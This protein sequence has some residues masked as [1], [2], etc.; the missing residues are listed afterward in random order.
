MVVDGLTVKVS[1][2]HYVMNFVLICTNIDT[3]EHA[4]TYYAPS[5]AGKAEDY[6]K[7]VHCGE[8]GWAIGVIGRWGSRVDGLGLYCIVS[9]SAEPL[10]TPPPAKPI[11]HTARGGPT[12]A[13][14]DKPPIKVLNGDDADQNADN[15]DDGGAG[16]ATAA[17]DT[18]IYDQ[19]DGSDVAY[20]SGGDPVTIVSCNDDNWCRISK[21]QNGWVW[22]DDLDR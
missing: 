19:P 10:N 17:T 3:H 20:L 14:P 1:T 12:T 22:G 16:G 7:S 13:P 11:K 4:S 5:A 21:P 8:N 6:T 2:E 15:G 9:R 18:T